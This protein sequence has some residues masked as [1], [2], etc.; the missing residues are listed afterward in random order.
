[1]RKISMLLQEPYL[2]LT[3]RTL[4]KLKVSSPG[5]IK[6]SV[7]FGSDPTARLTSWDLDGKEKLTDIKQLL[8]SNTI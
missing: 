1:M 4:R 2:M 8:N 6:N 3:T 7:K 5:K